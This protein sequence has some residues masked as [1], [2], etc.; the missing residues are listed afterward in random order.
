VDSE[1]GA[2]RGVSEDLVR[3]ARRRIRLL[4]IGLGTYFLIFLNTVRFAHRVPY[5]LFVLGAL[6]NMAIVT[7]IFILLRGAYRELN[8]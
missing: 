1:K 6:F 8:K 7:G 3:K 5:R 4:W 2:P